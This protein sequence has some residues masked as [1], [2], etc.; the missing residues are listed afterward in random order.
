MIE[1]PRIL[2]S[3]LR[4]MN[5]SDEKRALARRTDLE[6]LAACEHQA[7]YDERRALLSQDQ[8]GDKENTDPNSPV[9]E[10]PPTPSHYGLRNRTI[11]TGVDS[12]DKMDGEYSVVSGSDSGIEMQAAP[13]TPK[14]T[15]RYSMDEEKAVQGG[16]YEPLPRCFACPLLHTTL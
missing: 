3:Q 12:S 6:I 14:R 2:T 4:K 7:Q 5:L 10:A 13:S 1:T 15:R 16:E 11:G 8:I 9:P